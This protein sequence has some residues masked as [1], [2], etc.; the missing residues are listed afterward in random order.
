MRACRTCALSSDFLCPLNANTYDIEFIN[1]V[2]SDY[3]TKKVLFE[4]GKDCPPPPDMHID[5]TN[6]EEDS[7]RRIRYEFSEDVL[8]LPIIQTT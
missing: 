3:E 5:M 6:Y 8:R 2:I 1:F 4:V 7:F